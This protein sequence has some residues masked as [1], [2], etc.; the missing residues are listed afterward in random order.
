MTDDPGQQYADTQL[1]HVI[2]HRLQHI[3]ESLLADRAAWARKLVADMRAN[4][5]YHRE[6]AQDFTPAT[7]NPEATARGAAKAREALQRRID[8]AQ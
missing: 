4:G 6:P 5:W 3:P 1:V 7:P 8:H 2:T